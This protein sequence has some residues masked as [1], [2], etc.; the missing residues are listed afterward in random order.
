MYLPAVLLKGTA[1]IWDNSSTGIKKKK[2]SD[3]WG[4]LVW[5]ESKGLKFESWATGLK[6]RGAS[7][8]LTLI[9]LIIVPL[10]SLFS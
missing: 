1:T 8:L 7:A 9:S 5:E 4:Y 2:K 10:I 3:I 6:I